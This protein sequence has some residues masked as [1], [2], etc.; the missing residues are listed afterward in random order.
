MTRTTPA[1]VGILGAG[2]QA[3]ETAGYLSAEG[4]GIA[5]YF[6]ESGFV[7]T[8]ANGATVCEPGSVGNDDLETP[9]IPAV[10]APGTRRRLVEAWPGAAWATIVNRHAWVA[11]D[12]IVG[13]GT[14][15]APGAVLCAGTRVGRFCII[16]PGATV[17]HD[18]T[19][20]D[21]TLIAA[22]A[23]VAKAKI[24]QG[25][26]VGMN[27]VVL[28]GI[29]VGVGAVVGAGAV[30]TRDVAENEVVA[31]VPSRVLRTNVEWLDVL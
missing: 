24:G 5:F 26:V 23:R 12:A 8:A 11:S 2:R 27:A 4:I 31:G 29:T 3:A 30:V 1:R 16:N 6:V 20:G 28:P 14:T 22:G 15:V 25:V 10:G 9:V 21:H 18:T 7:R 19:I 17:H 13:E